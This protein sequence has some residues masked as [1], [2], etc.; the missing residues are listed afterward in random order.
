MSQRRKQLLDIAEDFLRVV[1]RGLC[2]PVSLLRGAAENNLWNI[3][4]SSLDILVHK[5]RYFITKLYLES[6]LR[7][8]HSL[9]SE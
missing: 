1:L 8:Y 6:S 3:L 7:L 5:F 4:D 9:D 2:A